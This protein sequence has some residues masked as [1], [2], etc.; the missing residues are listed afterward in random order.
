MDSKFHFPLSYH[1]FLKKGKR[2]KPT[3]W[4][5]TGII[6]PLHCRAPSKIVKGNSIGDRHYV[7]ISLRIGGFTNTPPPSWIMA[8]KFHLQKFSFTYH[9]FKKFTPNR[10]AQRTYQSLQQEVRNKNP[11]FKACAGHRLVKQWWCERRERAGVARSSWVLFIPN[12]ALVC[13]GIWEQKKKNHEMSGW[14]S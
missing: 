3:S 11:K 4:I 5:I 9:S 12:Q 7:I 2:K 14:N 1:P 13:L 8:T 10:P 6:I